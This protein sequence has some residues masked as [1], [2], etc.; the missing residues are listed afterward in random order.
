MT[1]LT[2]QLEPQTLIPIS[3]QTGSKSDELQL[4]FSS[5]LSHEY[6]AHLEALMFFNPQQGKF[7]NEIVRSIETHGKP[8]IIEEKGLLRIAIGTTTIAQT[9][10]CLNLADGAL[11]GTVVYMREQP[12]SLAI[13][14]LAVNEDYSASGAHASQLLVMQLIE[15]V[16]RIGSRIKGIQYITVLYR[17]SKVHRIP[18]RHIYQDD[19]GASGQ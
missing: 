10:F 12:E 8:K 2:S 1:P 5:R 9:L 6:Y 16:R 3:E 14:H 13:V 19:L 11:V 4:A 15:Q 18:V 7:R 17:E